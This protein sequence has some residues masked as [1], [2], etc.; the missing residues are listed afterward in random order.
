MVWV[1]N[2]GKDLKTYG[3]KGYEVISIRNPYNS[4]SFNWQGITFGTKVA[5]LEEFE[6]PNTYKLLTFKTKHHE[7]RSQ[8][9][10]TSKA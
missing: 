6:S 8:R 2:Q 9:Y 7:I 5:L 3:Y 10:G 4:I 1:Q